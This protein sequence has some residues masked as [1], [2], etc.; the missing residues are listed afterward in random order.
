MMEPSSQDPNSPPAGCRWQDFQ[1]S[2]RVGCFG[3]ELSPEIPF[4]VCIHVDA[5]QYGD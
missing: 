3:C 1:A 5:W 4:Y 2:H